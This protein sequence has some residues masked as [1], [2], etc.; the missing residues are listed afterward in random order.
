MKAT[1]GKGA[2]LAV[3][4][5]GGSVFAECVRALAYEGR[6]AIVGYVDRVM[7]G[8]VDIEAVH[9]KRLRIVGVSNKLRSADQRASTVRGFVADF[10]PLIAS[11]RIKPLIDRSFTFDEL[12]AAKAYMETDAHIGKIVVRV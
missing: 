5:V 3:N 9:V 4:N 10:L 11:G 12:P 7:K 8:E 1:D 6:L 2:N